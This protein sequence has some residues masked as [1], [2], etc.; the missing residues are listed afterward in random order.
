V[1]VCV[2]IRTRVY[3]YTHV[4]FSMCLY[5]CVCAYARTCTFARCVFTPARVDV[6]KC[7]LRVTTCCWRVC[8]CTCWAAGKELGGVGKSKPSSCMQVCRVWQYRCVG[9]D[10]I[11]TI[12]C[13]RIHMYS[14]AW[15]STHMHMY[16]IPCSR[17]HNTYVNTIPC[18]IIHNTYVNTIPRSRMQYKS[19][20]MQ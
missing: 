17:I 14:T 6:R 2:C 12:P 19:D 10:N 5:V 3:E 8:T 15:Y 9:F 20:T 4:H 16:T 11:N 18:S 7:A 1:C 13:S